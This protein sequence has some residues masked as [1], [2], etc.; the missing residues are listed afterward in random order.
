MVK[1]RKI[2]AGFLMIALLAVTLLQIPNHSVI[3]SGTPPPTGIVIV[4]KNATTSFDR[5]WKWTITKTG[6]N[7]SITLSPG[8]LFPVNYTVTVQAVAVDSNWKVSGQISFQNTSSQPAVITAV[9]D[10]ISGGIVANVDCGIAF[11]FTCPLVSPKFVPTRHLSLM[12]PVALT[13]P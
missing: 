3:A 5:E 13:Q 1:T 7:S 11:P 4:K 6:D 10:V 12:V 8:Q 2:M 9:T